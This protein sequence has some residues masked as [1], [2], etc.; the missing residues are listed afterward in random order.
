MS[1]EDIRKEQR[2]RRQAVLAAMDAGALLYEQRGR[3]RYARVE[4]V[5]AWEEARLHRPSD[6]VGPGY[7][8]HPALARFAL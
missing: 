5:R 7:G 6:P 3:A 8:V 1:V 4:D 2:C